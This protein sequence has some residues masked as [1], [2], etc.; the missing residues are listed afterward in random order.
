MTASYAE[1]IG[2]PIAQS[3]SPIVHGFWLERLGRAGRYERCH[4]VPAAL[5][6]YFAARRA[7][8]DWRGCNVTL[9]HKQAVLPLLDRVDPAAARIGAVNT[10]V[11]EN[12]LLIGHNSDAPGFLEPLRPWLAERHLLR[13]ARIFGTGGAAR[14]IAHA[15]WDE[16]FTLIVAAR[17]ETKARALADEFS[18]RDCHAASLAHFAA[19]L[20]FDWG[21]MVGRLDLVINATSLGMTGQPPLSLDFDHVPPGAIVYDAVYSPLETPLLAEARRRGHPVID[22]LAM[23]IGQARSAFTRFFGIEPPTDPASDAALRTLLVA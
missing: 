17:D 22:G 10:V 8:P 19:P 9:P 4:V 3:K 2:D 14:A 20:A 13:T 16:G 7:D 5:E 23:L 18:T 1:V 11:H 12:G 15:L 6:D 21:D